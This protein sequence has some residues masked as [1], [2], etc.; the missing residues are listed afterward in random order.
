MSLSYMNTKRTK[1][2]ISVV[3]YPCGFFLTPRQIP[4]SYRLHDDCNTNPGFEKMFDDDRELLRI[5]VRFLFNKKGYDI[6]AVHV[7]DHHLVF[8]RCTVNTLEE[9]IY[10]ARENID[11][12]Y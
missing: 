11:A 10:L 9:F 2:S 7:V 6:L 3:V 1:R 8:T 4:D 12:F 5:G